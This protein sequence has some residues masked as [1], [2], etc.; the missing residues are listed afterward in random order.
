MALFRALQ[1][2]Q[3][4]KEFTTRLISLPALEAEDDG[5]VVSVA[6]SSINYKDGLSAAGNPGV[7]RKFPHIPGID[8]VGTVVE[9]KS[10]LFSAG[11]RILVTGY[12]LGMNTDGGLAEQLKIPAAW[13]LK[14]PEQL[15]NLD[16]MVLGTAGLTAFL[17]LDRLERAGLEPGASIVI[18]GAGGGVG[19]VAVAL[20]SLK[21]YKVTAV[22]AKSEQHDW[23]S[24]LGAAEIIGREELSLNNPRPLLKPR[25]DAGIDC[26][27]GDTLANMVKSV[28]YGGSVAAC[29]LA[30][31]T[32]LPLTVL[33][34]ILKGV[35]LLGVDSVELPL[36]TKQ[37]AWQ[38][39]AALVDGMP[40]AKL[41]QVINLEQAL[42]AL[43]EVLT[44]SVR[45]RLVVDVQA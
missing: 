12:D 10:S 34:F 36:A 45:G 4:E 28:A 38:S 11:D 15:T 6:Y 40:M 26:A 41:H 31:S 16:A 3:D 2:T 19:S 27:G 13:A 22:S 18:S 5:L 21:G 24:A 37:A 44:G 1:T 30:Q 39:I 25:W 32:E 20:A 14:L 42:V 8:A 9:S 7:T 29:G 33:P 23:L 43:Q 17:C 35:A